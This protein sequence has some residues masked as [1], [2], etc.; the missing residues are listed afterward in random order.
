MDENQNNQNPYTEAPQAEAPQTEAPQVE[1]PQTETPQVDAPQT[2]APQVD[3][4]QVDPYTTPAPESEMKYT[5]SQADP[6]VSSQADPYAAPQNDPYAA[7]Q[8]DPY[9]AP[10]QNTYTA[11]QQ[12]AY[13][14]QGD[15]YGQNNSYSDPYGQQPYGSQTSAPTPGIQP[16][17]GKA[18]ASLVI[19]II[20]LLLCTCCFPA[21]V[22]IA[23][24]ILSKLAM[25]AGNTS[26]KAKAG[27]ILG[28]I[29]VVIAVLFIIGWL[30]IF[31]TGNTA[32]IQELADY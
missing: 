24:I 23:S 5:D 26:G 1:T 8:N 32:M 12:N 22:G 21:P 10:Q 4:P 29:N 14:P 18:T 20:S 28:I 17:D 25:N 9:A 6:S 2:E 11:P 19:G 16:E 3:A 31:I 27:M 15:T 13:M 7:P 30:I